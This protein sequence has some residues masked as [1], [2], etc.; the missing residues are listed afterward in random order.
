[1]DVH[2]RELRALVAVAEEQSVTRAAQRLFLAQPALSRQLQAL[3]R[4]LGVPLLERLP[5]GVA[6]TE[7][8][9]ALLGP[10][11]EAVAAWERG[12]A[13]ALATVP[14]GRLVVGMQTAVGRGLQRRALARFAELSPGTVPVLRQVDWRDPTAGLADG[15]SDVAFVWLP[16]PMDDADV[17]PVAREERV[18]ALPSDHRLAGAPRV[19]LADL[20]DEPFI[21]LPDSAGPLR[22]AWLAVADRGGRPPVVGAVADTPDAV[23]EA[24]A[25]GLG[26]VLLAAGNADLYARPGIVC[27]PVEGLAPAVLALAWRRSDRRPVVAAFV[28]AV[29]DRS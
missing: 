7:A 13:A 15:S 14:A 11:R 25:S 9:R 29:D 3:E 18:V 8:G 20:L 1:V 28:R 5:R 21:A 22:D 10:A 4:R 17:L 12:L 6:L 19:V 16:L 24:V 27:R 23:F 26:V 2:L